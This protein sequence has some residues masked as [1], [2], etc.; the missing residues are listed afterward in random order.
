M[1]HY[2]AHHNI[3]GLLQLEKALLGVVI[4]TLPLPLSV[5]CV[6]GVAFCTEM[7][8]HMSCIHVSCFTV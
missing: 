5:C 4:A 3:F 2:L 1:T 7:K 8:L 6:D